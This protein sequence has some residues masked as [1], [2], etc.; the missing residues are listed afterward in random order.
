MQEKKQEK[1]WDQTVRLD[2]I[3]FKDLLTAMAHIVEGQKKLAD[4]LTAIEGELKLIRVEIS[5]KTKK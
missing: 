4:R 1:L 5:E 2:P 3:Q